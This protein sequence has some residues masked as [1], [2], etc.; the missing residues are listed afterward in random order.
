MSCFVPSL[1][2]GANFQISVHSWSNTRAIWPPAADGH[3]LR[4][5]WEVRVVVDGEVN[6]MA[7]LPVDAQWPQ[8]ICE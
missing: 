4:E 1:M 5:L 8:I 6:T 2:A 7:H 3:Q